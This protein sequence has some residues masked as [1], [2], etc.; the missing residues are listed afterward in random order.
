MHKKSLPVL[1]GLLIALGFGGEG[2][3]PAQTVLAQGV[4][5]DSGTSAVAARKPNII[6]ILMDDLGYGDVGKFWQN[7]RPAGEPSFKTPNWDRMADEGMMLM[8]HYCAAPVCAPSRASLML[9]QDQ[10]H[11]G[12]RNDEFDFPLPVDHTMATVLKEQGYRTMIVGKWGL[13]GLAPPWPR[14]PF[15]CGFD[16]FYG[17]MKHSEG[18]QHYPG[19]GGSVMDGRTPV[20]TGLKGV[21]T[22]DLWTAKAKQLIEEQVSQRPN[23]PF[24]MYLAYDTPHSA[25]QVPLG[26]YPPGQGLNGGFQWPVPTVDVG[27][28]KRKPWI[29]PDMVSEP[30]PEKAKLQATMIRRDDE[31]VGD[32]MQL[33]RDLHIDKDTLVVFSSDNGPMGEGGESPVYFGSWGPYDG[34]KRDVYEGGIHMPAIAWWPGHIAAGSSTQLLSGLWDWLPTFAEAAGVTPPGS[35]DGVSLLPTLLGQGKQQTHPYLYFEYKGVTY[36]ENGSEAFFQ[37]KG[38]TGRGE[39]QALRIDDF[40]GLRYQIVDPNEPLRLYNLKD[41]VHEDHDIAGEPD[42][43]AMLAEMNPLLLTARDN[44]PGADRPYGQQLLPADTVTRSTPGLADEEYV[45]SWPWVPD[46]VALAGTR[47]PASTGVEQVPGPIMVDK[48]NKQPYVM[49]AHGYLNAPA[50]G[51]YTFFMQEDGGGHLWIHD[52]HVIN[53]DFQHTGSEQSG[54]VYLQKGQHPIRIIYR[55]DKGQASLQVSWSGPDLP[56]TALPPA[57]LTHEP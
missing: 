3:V 25:E 21:Y 56:K 16:V 32:V 42:S 17:Y 23:Q 15:E 10:G 51:L 20:T 46:F 12:L 4:G 39:M 1:F 53:D 19:N 11:C 40:A 47:T 24:F 54:T 38:V 36:H 30:W 18:H 35:I 26:P 2:G 13:G 52:A 7:Q 22:T 37:R 9:G 5:A 29:Y 8:Q 27:N 6:V 28:G 14:H 50:D 41:D 33:L 55:H 48:E 43:A 34:M 49:V 31:G 44:V 45:G 57:A